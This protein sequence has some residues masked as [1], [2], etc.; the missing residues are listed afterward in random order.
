M[1]PP[2]PAA[3]YWAGEGAMQQQPQHYNQQY[4]QVYQQEYPP[5]ANQQYQ[6]YNH[7]YTQSQQNYY[8]NQPP[9]NYPPNQPA[10]SDGWEDNW[11]WGWDESA[12]QAQKAQNSAHPP[13]Q[14]EQVFNN[15]NVLE[16]SFAPTNTWNWAM[17]GKKGS[18]ESSTLPLQ[19]SPEELPTFPLNTL[20]NNM[21]VEPANIHGVKNGA[22]VLPEEVRTLDDRDI[23][24]ERM[25]NLAIGKR[26]NLE[27]LT[28]QWSIESQMSQE[29]SDGPHTHTESTYRSEN[30]SRNSNSP[31]PNI[32]NSNYNYS[33]SR[34]HMGYTQNS[35]ISRQ[36]HEP[37]PAESAQTGSRRESHE[38][39]AHTLRDLSLV[40]H[41]NPSSENLVASPEMEQR[42]SQQS[43]SF[44]PPAFVESISALPP[45]MLVAVSHP[46]PPT[47]SM[48]PPPPV[49]A[50]A[51]PPSA[52]A[53]PSLA[54]MPPN[55]PPPSNSQN[56]FKHAGPLTHNTK[57]SSSSLSGQGYPAQGSGSSL[58]SPAVVGKASKSPAPIG[59]EANLETTPDNSERPD[60]PARHDHAAPAGGLRVPPLAP[61]HV[62]DN[63]EVAPQNDRNEYL[64]TAH[65]S[66]ND[67][68][69]NA[70]FARSAPPPPP[71]LRRMV[72]G[73]QEEYGRSGADDPP[74]GLARMVPG[75]QTEADG[76]CDQPT[77]PYRASDRYRRADGEYRA[78][79]AWRPPPEQ[80]IVPGFERAAAEREPDLDGS[81]WPPPAPEER[82]APSDNLQDPSTITSGDTAY[83]RERAL[84]PDSPVAAEHAPPSPARRSSADTDRERSGFEGEGRRERRGSRDRDGDGRHSRPDRRERDD[85]KAT[86][87]DHRSE[88]R[89]RWDRD[90]NESPDARRK[91]RS[92]RAHRYETE[93]TDCYSDKERDR[94]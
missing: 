66:T 52:G 18:Q 92:V 1:H 44:A 61:R 53:Q 76:A 87:D 79:G 64:Q 36:Y 54:S 89:D 17:D 22:T 88:R 2:Q 40:N 69:E 6:Q 49:S 90:R 47:L 59:F 23:V 9:Q 86:R 81:A 74:P 34:L 60:H 63:M 70:E 51:R 62:P 28:P 20:E 85:R 32:D 11:D 77:E 45:P 56:P 82:R 68:G 58:V 13:M 42:H 71:G 8:Q 14:Q 29:S 37:T 5:N 84:E 3:A 24:K 48:P 50:P 83:S 75:R 80:R 16:E 41:E 55:F 10:N 46:P 27:N 4:A 72:L 67:Y 33:Q 15:A 57:P 26:F 25:P 93:D 65:L 78:A 38:E 7:N 43:M 39:L 12:K 31:D 73:R 30:Q 21:A 35:E 94:R 91:R 19:Q